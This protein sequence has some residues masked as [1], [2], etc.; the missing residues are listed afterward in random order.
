VLG[1]DDKTG[2][3]W[4]ALISKSLTASASA[5]PQASGGSPTV[6]APPS[7]PTR[8]AV[9]TDNFD[10]WPLDGPIGN[11]WELAP[12]D[13]RGSLTAVADTSKAGRDALLK[14]AASSTVRACKSFAPAPIDGTMAAVRVRLDGIGGADA[15]ITSLRDPSGEAVSVRFGQGGTFAYYA[16]NI[17]V[18]TAVPI[19]LATWY[20]SEVTI[21]PESRTYDWRLYLEDGTLVVRAKGIR[22]RDAAAQQVSEL[23][24][25]TSDRAGVGLRF[26]D[27]RVTR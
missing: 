18:R 11:G 2:I 24:V 4:H 5:T 14:P 1:F 16:G 6:S 3:Y 10:P 15:V 13:V 7:V 22:Y 20:R 23:C 19:R 25:Q 12:A 27:V 21:H 26:D 9:F 17:K 8:T